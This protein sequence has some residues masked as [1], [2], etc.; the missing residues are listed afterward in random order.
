MPLNEPANS[1]RSNRSTSANEA[2]IDAVIASA[3]AAAVAERQ[4]E[5]WAAMLRRHP[6]LMRSIAR[7]SN[8]VFAGRLGPDPCVFLHIVEAILVHGL[9]RQVPRVALA[10]HAEAHGN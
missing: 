6:I 2:D 10:H 8:V 4:R 1:R 3:S 5:T 7:T 9:D